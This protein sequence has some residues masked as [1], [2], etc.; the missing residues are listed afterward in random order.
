MGNRAKQK[1]NHETYKDKEYLTYEE[2][3]DYLG[4]KRSTLYTLITELNITTEKFKLD[5]KRYLSIAS[6]KK[7]KE[8][9]DKPWLLNKEREK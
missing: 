6:V 7:I 2:A 9:R 5:K 3:M 1:P 8:V 4:I